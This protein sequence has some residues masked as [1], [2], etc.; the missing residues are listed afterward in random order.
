MSKVVRALLGC[1][2]LDELA[3]QLHQRCH[4]A[5]GPLAQLRT[6]KIDGVRQA[7]KAVGAKVRYLPA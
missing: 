1:K 4:G 5:S 3:D 7:V 6:H 2:C